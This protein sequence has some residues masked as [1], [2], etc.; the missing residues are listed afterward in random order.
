MAICA[1]YL[2]YLLINAIDKPNA[3]VNSPIKVQVE[4]TA[5]RRKGYNLIHY[6]F[7]RVALGVVVTAAQLIVSRIGSPMRGI[8]MDAHGN[9]SM[10]IQWCPWNITHG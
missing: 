6:S 2:H 9:M 1:N 3:A 10:D 4:V 7:R 5:L 8:C